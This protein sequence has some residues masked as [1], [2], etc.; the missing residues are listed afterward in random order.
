LAIS[1]LEGEKKEKEK[2]KK[3]RY[4]DK[5]ETKLEYYRAKCSSLCL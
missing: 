5:I 3:Y 1:N 2:D 4:E